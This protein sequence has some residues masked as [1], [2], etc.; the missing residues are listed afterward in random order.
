[1]KLRFCPFGSAAR[2]FGMLKPL[3]R[4][5]HLTTGLVLTATLSATRLTDHKGG[6]EH[7]SDNHRDLCARTHREAERDHPEHCHA[8]RKDK[9]PGNSLAWRYAAASTIDPL[10]FIRRHDQI[11]KAHF[12]GLSEA[13]ITLL[14][15]QP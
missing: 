3:L 4:D 8:E 11:S 14:P 7:S 9:R 2:S 13:L 12:R 6:D 15:Q 5:R 1:M 10:L